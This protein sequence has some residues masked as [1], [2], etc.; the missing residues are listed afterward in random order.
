MIKN[1]VATETRIISSNIIG[2]SFSADYFQIYQNGSLVILAGMP[3]PKKIESKTRG[4]VKAALV[5][6]SIYYLCK[7]RS[8]PKAL[9][10]MV[11]KEVYLILREHGI[12]VVAAYAAYLKIKIFNFWYLS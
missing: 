2:Y 11:E 12:S 8:I 10:S 3:V 9:L 5:L 6:A 4:I 7:I 1:E